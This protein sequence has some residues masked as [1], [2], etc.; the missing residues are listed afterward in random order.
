MDKKV[1]ILGAIVM[2]DDEIQEP[3]EYGGGRHE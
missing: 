1:A 2:C 3:G